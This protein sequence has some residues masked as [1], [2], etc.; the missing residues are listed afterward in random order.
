MQRLLEQRYAIK[1]CVKLKKSGSET[2]GL[3]REAFGEETM[4]Q[5]SIFEWHKMFREG[6]ENIDDNERSGRPS[7]SQ[8]DQNVEKVRKVLY[9]DRRLSVR[10]I[11]EDC[12]MP[13]SN[14]YRILTDE[15]GMRKVCAKMVPK[16]LTDEQKEIRVLKCRELLERRKSDP[17]FLNRVVTG[18]ETWI[19]EYDPE[20][21]RQ[22]SEWHTKN[23]PRPKKARMSKSRVKAMLV[24]FFD[25]K[26]VIHS[27]FVP[28]GQTV[29]GQFYAQVLARLR[30]RVKRVRKDIANNWILH[31]DNAPS[32]TAL[33]VQEFLARNGVA[34]L[35]QPPYSPDLAPPDFFL[36]PRIKRNLKG[37]HHG[38]LAGIK[39]ASTRCL[40]EV[41]VGAFQEAYANWAKRWQRCVDAEGMYFEDF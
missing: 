29:N 7:T 40:K 41:P 34:T 28:Q 5:T 19:F 8:T 35:P 1:F 4:S 14:V 3:I 31:H 23:S 26:G 37:Y 2:V 16:V 15:L 30:D 9:G 21:K 17:N 22:S 25:S 6:R 33:V 39:E 36:F 38:T 12:N 20:T 32:H 10:M 11:G 13:K 27:E 18:D 24:V